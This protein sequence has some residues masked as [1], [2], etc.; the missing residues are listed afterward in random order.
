MKAT[1]SNSMKS[2]L[3]AMLV[4]LALGCT[5]LKAQVN[6][7]EITGSVNVDLKKNAIENLVSN[8]NSENDGVRKS[9]IY[10]AGYYKVAETM[11]ALKGQFKKESDPSVRIL[12]AL[13]LYKLGNP[14]GMEF[15]NTYAKKDNDTKV[16]RMC[17]AIY[18]DYLMSLAR[19][20]AY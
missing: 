11:N 7:D 10:Y 5:S 3:T 4:I 9:A 2:V 6:V 16:R 13:S 20:A 15:I 19:V 8:I 17:S 1:T 12:I 18:G 14:D